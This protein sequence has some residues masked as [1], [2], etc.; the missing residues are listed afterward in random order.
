[1]TGLWYTSK[2]K[3]VIILFYLKVYQTRKIWFNK[4]KLIP[5]YIKKKGLIPFCIGL[6]ALK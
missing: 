3:I 6:S 1:M 2:N 5:F 4:K